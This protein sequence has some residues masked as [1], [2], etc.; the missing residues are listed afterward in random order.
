MCFQILAKSRDLGIDCSIITK[1]LLLNTF[2]SYS[3]K[4]GTPEHPQQL[5]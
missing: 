1:I 4:A 5:C 3:H 2:S